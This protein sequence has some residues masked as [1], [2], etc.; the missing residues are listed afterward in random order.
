MNLNQSDLY[1]IL[2]ISPT[3]TA[4]E[5]KIAYRKMVLKYHP[6]KNLTTD[7]TKKFLQ[8][9]LAYEILSDKA[10]RAEY[11]EMDNLDDSDPMNRT[12]QIKHIYV[13]YQQLIIDICS[14]YQIDLAD[15]DILYHLF[16]PSDYTTEIE[17]GNWD[18]ISESLYIKLCECGS[19][20]LLNRIAGSNPLMAQLCHLFGDFD[21]DFDF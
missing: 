6:D 12:R 7:T 9:Q 13:I 5:I 3:A 1:M 11:D 20:I 4:D 14:K 8:I 18:K 2:N 19:K 15:R 10:R 16:N 21:F 17:N